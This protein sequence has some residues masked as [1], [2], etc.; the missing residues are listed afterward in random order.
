MKWNK[1]GYH[2]SF[3]NTAVS[4]IHINLFNLLLDWTC[5]WNCVRAQQRRRQQVCFIYLYSLCFKMSLTA[6]SALLKCRRRVLSSKQLFQHKTVAFPCRW[7]IQVRCGGRG[8]IRLWA[9]SVN[10]TVLPHRR[11]L[12][13][14]TKGFS[15]GG[16]LKPISSLTC[17][18]SRSTKSSLVERYHIHFLCKRGMF[19]R[20][21]RRQRTERKG[22]FWRDFG[23]SPWEALCVF[24]LSS[25]N[26]TA[27]CGDGVTS[28]SASIASKTALC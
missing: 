4:K 8:G 7:L 6:I 18:P 26:V 5:F 9:V 2:Q 15:P 11:H 27:L 10:H 12:S 25:F 1:K 21:S 23:I 3:N 22:G 20:K 19:Q 28:W 13:P 17:N 16:T 14:N 24:F